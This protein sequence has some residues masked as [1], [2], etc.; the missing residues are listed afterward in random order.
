MKIGDIFIQGGFP[1]HAVIVIDLARDSTCQK[2]FLLAQG[3]TPAQDIHILKN[4]N[5]ADLNPWYSIP[6]GRLIT[7][8][9]TFDKSDLM[10]FK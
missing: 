4:D 5:D 8:D 9:W 3:F 10:R 6:E 1:G 7:P 2:L